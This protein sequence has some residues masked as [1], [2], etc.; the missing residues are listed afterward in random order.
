MLVSLGLRHNLAMICVTSVV[1][2]TAL[3]TGA[4]AQDDAGADLDLDS[5]AGPPSSESQ[6]LGELEVISIIINC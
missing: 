4:W 6:S 2:V 5:M 1:L 3:V